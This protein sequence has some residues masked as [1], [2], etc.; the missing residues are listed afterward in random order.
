MSN[1]FERMGLVESDTPPLP[2][3]ERV[4]TAPIPAPAPIIVT[5]SS[6]AEVTLGPDDQAAMEALKKQVY[7]VP[8]SFII[9]RD[10]ASKMGADSTPAKVFD[11]LSVANP[12]VTRAKV[13]ADI[14][15]HLGVLETARHDFEAK[16]AQATDARV[17]KPSAQIAT[18]NTQIVD[19]KAK[20]DALTP[21]VQE[22]LVAIQGGTARFHIIE[23]QLSAPL[24]Q[25][26]QL[27]ANSP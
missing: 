20:I 27:L 9:Y 12:S 11:F 21:Q 6:G 18:M 3:T 14:D 10:M 22:A 26:K 23:D 4:E 5:H 25:A 19:L 2:R 17:T 8:S 24:L 13:L 7:A 15:A 16:I 1:I